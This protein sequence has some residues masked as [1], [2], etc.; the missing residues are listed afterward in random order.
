MKSWHSLGIK[1]R[2]TASILNTV[3]VSTCTVQ[4]VLN[5]F[6]LELINVTRPKFGGSKPHPLLREEPGKEA[7]LTRMLL[8]AR[9]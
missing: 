8:E 2:N 6:E 7:F 1:P 3:L 5:Q 4:V 9:S